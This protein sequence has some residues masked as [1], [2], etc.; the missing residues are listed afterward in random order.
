MV[1]H[2]ADFEERC[3]FLSQAYPTYTHAIMQN[4]ASN[5]RWPVD[6]SNS[7]V[8]SLLHLIS[9]ADTCRRWAL[10]FNARTQQYE[11]TLY[12]LAEQADGLVNVRNSETNTGL[13][14]IA[15]VFLPG[16]FIAV[17]SCSPSAF[18][19]TTLTCDAGSFQYGLLHLAQFQG[20]GAEMDM[21]ILRRDSA[22]Y[23]DRVC[24]LAFVEG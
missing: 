2:L 23:H 17:G 24:H 5:Q 14:V 22:D 13:S 6:N 19:R 21:A 3:R 4:S 15:M 8:D 16:T 10:N 9:G 11:M 18:Q 20:P 12:H 7:V 1:E